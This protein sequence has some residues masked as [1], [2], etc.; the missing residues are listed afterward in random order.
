VRTRS[1]HGTLPC[2][3][4]VRN[5][6]RN[7]TLRRVAILL[8]LIA[9]TTLL[10]AGVAVTQVPEEDADT[11]IVV[12][13]DSVDD[14]S[15]VAEGID[16][17]QEGF[18][19][20]FVYTE[21]LEGFSAEIP[22]DSLDDVRNNSRVAYVERD[23]VVTAFGQRVPWGIRRIGANVSS[24]RA[25]NGSGKV[26]GVNIYVIDSGIAANPDLNVVNRHNFLARGPDNDCYGHGTH[27]AGT[28]A[29]RDNRI[30]VVGVAP[31]APLTSVKV[32]D[33]HGHGTA[34][35]VIKGIDWVTAKAAKAEKPAV[36][37]MSLGSSRRIKSLNTAVR[38]SAAS[39]VFYSLSAGNEGRSACKFSPAMTGA[40][41]NNGILTT[42]ATNS[43]D[44]EPSW[45]NFGRCVDLWAPG[46]NILS[47]W[48]GGATKTISGTSMAAPHVGGTAALYLSA[49]P[50]RSPARVEADLKAK[51]TEPG[52][53]SKGGKRNIRL[54][55]ASEY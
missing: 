39:G 46:A 52:A 3:V 11:Y 16:Q 9:A 40:G 15:Q 7:S 24:I 10:A 17:R 36:A 34:G 38:T 35:K 55:N 37:N 42:A 12:L 2:I 44:R 28:L 19:A 23:E 1:P 48:L 18:D 54:I 26:T 49:L 41:K 31:G 8:A 5:Q 13:K 29:A 51:S 4:S 30:D 47:T 22:D 21:A 32:L 25:G 14:P 27:V 43:A 53:K 50:T 6:G 33:C 20:G 45:S